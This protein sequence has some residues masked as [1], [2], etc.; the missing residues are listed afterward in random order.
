[1][2]DNE[3]QMGRFQPQGP[4]AGA[5]QLF[6]P[7]RGYSRLKFPFQTEGRV[8]QATRLFRPATQP[9]QRAAL[10]LF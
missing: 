10:V 7:I 5:A 4:P 2:L 9:A 1:M 6:K 3:Q 8:A